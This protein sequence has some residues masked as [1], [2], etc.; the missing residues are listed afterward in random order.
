VQYF[1]YFLQHQNQFY[2]CD[3][4]IIRPTQNCNTNV[5]YTCYTFVWHISSSFIRR[6]TGYR[7]KKFALLFFHAKTSTYNTL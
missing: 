4:W 2:I 3:I 7:S 6:S 5:T 1:K